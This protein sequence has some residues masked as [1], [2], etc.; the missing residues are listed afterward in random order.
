LTH[1]KKMGQH[2][3]THFHSFFV[4]TGGK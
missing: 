3:M 4:S 2:V 1:G